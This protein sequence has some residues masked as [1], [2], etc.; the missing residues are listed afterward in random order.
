MTPAL[1]ALHEPQFESPSRMETPQPEQIG[2][3]LLVPQQARHHEPFNWDP[4]VEFLCRAPYR[5][6]YGD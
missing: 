4:D 5:E 3:K 1:M 6:Q 2:T